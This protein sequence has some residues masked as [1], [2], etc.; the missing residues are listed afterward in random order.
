MDEY[1]HGKIVNINI[2]DE[3]K[4]SFMDYAMSVI[5]SRALPDVRDGLKPVHRRILYAMH[6][7]GLNPDK[8]HK[9]SAR[10]VGEVLGK[11]HPHGDVAVYEAMVRMAQDFSSRYPLADGH[12]NFGSVD[13]DS[14]AAMRYTEVR[15]AKIAEQMLIDIDKDTID[16]RPNFDDSLEEPVVLPARF[17]NLLVNGSSG[18]AVGMATNIPPH[19]LGEVID[20]LISIIDDPDVDGTAL[21]K[22]IKGPDFPTGGLILGQGGI[23]SA[24]RTGRGIIKMRAKT[25]IEPLKGDKTRITVTELPYQV[26]KARLV[27]TIADL[28]R[29]KKIEGI[30]DL[31]DESDRTGMRVII[32]LR[33]DVIPQVILNKLFKY[34]QLEQTFGVIMLALV[35]GQPR[36]L[37]LRQVLKEYLKHQKE[38]VTRRTRFD[39]RK[40]EARAHILEG[41]RIALSNLDAVIKLIRQ[42]K[43]VDEARKGLI[44]N[45]KLTEKQAQAILDMR[46]QKLTGLE[47]EKLEAEYLELIKKIAYL[48]EVLN[49]ERLIFQIIRTELLEVKKKFSDPRRTKIMPREEELH[50]EDLIAVED[51]VITLTHQGYIKR[52][53]LTTYRSQRRGGR[54]ITGMG[55]KDDDFVE[56]IFITS[57]HHNLLCISNHGKL[58]RLKVYEIPEAGR[59]AKGTNMINLLSLDRGEFITTVIPIRKFTKE[60]FLFFGTKKGYVKKTR[61]IEYQRARKGGLIALTLE[62]DDELIGARM[63]DGSREILLAT[64]RG[65]SIRFQESDVR[66]MGRAARGVKGIT[67]SPEDLVIGM[68]VV[69]PE[70]DILVVSEKGFG[71]RTAVE[72][73]RLQKRGGK[74]IYTLKVTPRTGPLVGFRGVQSGDELM[75]ITANGIII[76]QQISEI[77]MISRY[78][79]GVTLIKLDTGDRVVSL[80]RVPAK[81]GGAEMVSP[82][83]ISPN[84]RENGV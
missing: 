57:T 73:Y 16:Y 15:M 75:L 33:K 56:Q 13:G 60:D 10:L 83:S 24:Y 70:R 23:E 2:Q 5:V 29:T 41:L 66:T 77:S 79:Q 59:Q 11:Y 7:L 53:P 34:T 45:F 61:L 1:T 32:D 9:K 22:I 31:G 28:V 14:A 69:C 18:I 48:Q 26:N 82:E 43:T 63:T 49:N 54:G 62:S 81:S 39:L 38:V 55:T 19:N 74:G 25:T 27:E 40:A 71:K 37:S 72:E 80:A 20:G 44:S 68:Q 3:V 84:Q 67:L 17:P 35:D 51:A 52:L 46:L 47:R 6:E 8:P 36:V 30:T 4:N 78:A 64:T 12:G 65:L 58:Y 50:V 42:S 21:S 76:R